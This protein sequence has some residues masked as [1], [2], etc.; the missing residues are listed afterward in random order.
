MRELMDEEIERL[1]RLAVEYGAIGCSVAEIADLLIDKHPDLRSAP[2]RLV[3]VLRSAFGLSVHD[4]QYVTAW[5]Q[6]EISMETLEERLQ[7]TR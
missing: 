2:F 7:V 5:A 4:L 3:Q 1:A 6:G